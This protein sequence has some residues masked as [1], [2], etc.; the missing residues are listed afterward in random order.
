M[1]DEMDENL[2]EALRWFQEVFGLKVDG[3]P[4]GETRAE[5]VKQF[6]A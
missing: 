6:G 4:N 2:E 3:T 5:L 1:E